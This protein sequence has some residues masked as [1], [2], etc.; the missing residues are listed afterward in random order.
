ME[1]MTIGERIAYYR[2]KRHL[3]QQEL[4]KKCNVYH[5]TLSLYEN[6]KATPKMDTLRK[7]AQALDIPLKALIPD[8][9]M[10][11]NTERENSATEKEFLKMLRKIT[12][13]VEIPVL[14]HVHAGEPNEIPEAEI[15]DYLR[16]P[17]DLIDGGD[18]AL[19]IKGMSMKEAGINEGD[20]VIVKSQS[21][22]E[23]GQIV[24]ARINDSSEYTIKRFKRSMEK[25]WLEPANEDYQPIKT[26]FTIVG[27]IVCSV[28]K[29]I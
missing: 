8:E 28:K 2:K 21:Y 6:D 23:N 19:V 29:F 17:K 25:G 22:A 15:I 10:K 5:T 26:P 9:K 11:E 20:Y 14:G 24:I 12:D 27:V 7:I 16:L 1:R 4:A 3:T 18:Y 13:V